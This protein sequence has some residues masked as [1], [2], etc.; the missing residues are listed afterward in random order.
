M[1][2]ESV[3]QLLHNDATSPRSAT[4]LL[5][6]ARK[7]APSI[8]EAAGAIEQTRAL[9]QPIFETIAD[10]GLFLMAVPKA[11]GGHEVDFP[12]F[13][14]IIE[15]IARGDASAAWCVSQG[16]I[17]G[18]T[19]SARMPIEAARAIWIDVPRAV[20]ANTP[21]ATGKGIV[22]PG[23]FRVTGKHPFSSGAPHAAWFAAQ[24]PVI[25]N[26]QPRQIAR[27]LH[28][29]SGDAAT[30]LA[31]ARNALEAFYELAGSKAPRYQKNLLRDLPMTQATVG[32]AEATLRSAR[33]Y[34][35]EAVH[36]IWEDA[37]AGEVTM[38]SRTNLRIASTHA[39]HLAAEVVR[40]VYLSAGATAV[41]E[42]NVIQRMFQDVNVITQHVQSRMSHYD[43]VG[44][45][46]LGVPFE[47]QH[48]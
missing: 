1:D 42:G 4:A 14:R 31:I 19:Y 6:A 10:A 45:Y 11:V 17:F 47:E 23:G 33:A 9:P 46:V 5:D 3:N 38:E 35:M 37:V 28:F 36:Q 41:F 29:A 15:T 13:V 32:K 22:A 48:L 21:A 26:G 16:S 40:Q 30:S 34:L 44:K 43:T 39:I 12:T 25:E 18:G 27:S 24:G 20:V 2:S 7:L 8:R